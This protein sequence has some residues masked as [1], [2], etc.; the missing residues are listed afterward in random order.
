MGG[1]GGNVARGG[2]L[3]PAGVGVGRGRIR[4]ANT[5]CQAIRA[6]SYL[7]VPALAGMSDR[8]ANGRSRGSAGRRM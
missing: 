5:L 4:R 3:S 7:G 8:Y 2:G 1:E 6:F